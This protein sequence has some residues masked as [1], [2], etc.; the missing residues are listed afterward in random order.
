[1]TYALDPERLDLAREFRAKP[2]GTR[3]DELQRVLNLMRGGSSAGRLVALCLRRHR[4]WA[5]ARMGKTPLDP[6][7]RVDERVFHSFDDAEW[8]IFRI[9][10]RELTGRELEI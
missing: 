5:L 6:I 1:M 3:S 7:E 10:W 8:E 2:Y 4:E 9:R